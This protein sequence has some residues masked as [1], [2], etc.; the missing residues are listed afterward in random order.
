MHPA[1]FAQRVDGYTIYG[2]LCSLTLEV[3]AFEAGLSLLRRKR[4]DEAMSRIWVESGDPKIPSDGSCARFWLSGGSFF[5][6]YTSATSIENP[7]GPSFDS[8]TL[9]HH[10][11]LSFE[12]AAV[13]PV[14][15]RGSWA[16]A[17]TKCFS[18]KAPTLP[19]L[20]ENSMG[21]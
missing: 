16:S 9:W 2:F 6:G 15:G 5:F 1:S 21:F 10:F 19:F 7:C 8:R 11:S 14:L 18:Q 12:G 3:P 13:G 20:G 17:S 4:S